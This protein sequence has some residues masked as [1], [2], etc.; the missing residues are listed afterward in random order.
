MRGKVAFLL[1]PQDPA[2]PAETGMQQRVVFQIFSFDDRHQ[3]LTLRSLHDHAGVPDEQ[4]ATE[5]LL[6]LLNMPAHRA[7]A[8]KQLLRCSREVAATGDHQQ[9]LQ[10]VE[11]RIAFD[12]HLCTTRM[13]T[14]RF[15]RLWP[16][17]WRS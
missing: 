15:Y 11:G 4:R 1:Q 5:I 17:N 7:L 3:P 8:E 12:L 2:P 10:D 16:E 13:V 9:G 6:D 14:M